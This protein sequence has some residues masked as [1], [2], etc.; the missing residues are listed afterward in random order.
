MKETD[1]LESHPRRLMPAGAQERS[2]M[3]VR[4]W[5]AQPDARSGSRW[6]QWVLLGGDAALAMALA[7]AFY[8]AT[9]V[10]YEDQSRGI[11]LILLQTLPLALRRWY[12][13]SVLAVVVAATLGT[14]AAEIPGRSNGG[15]GVVLLVAL[16]SVAA[17]CPRREAAWAGI[18][19]GAV[20]AWPLWAATGGS[21]PLPLR[22]AVVAMSLVLPTLGW[23]CGAYVGELRGRAARSR[24][25]QE[26]ET[27]RAVAEEQARVGR[28][29]HD[30][31]AHTL[32]VIVIQAGAALDVFD[33]RPQAAR[34]ALGSIGSAGR[35]ALAELRRVL[36]AVRPQPGQEEDWAPPPGLSGLGE[37]LDRVRAAGLDVTARIDGAPVD[38]PAGLDLAAYR[39]VQEA[40]TNT[41]KHARAQAA[42]VHLCY[43]PAGLVL[44]VTDDGRPAAPA[45][46]PGLARGRG[47][48]GIRERA[49]LHGGTCQAGPR[50]GGGFAVRVAFPLPGDRPS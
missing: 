3:G 33:T 41:L 30:V 27:G 40:L 7:A 14:V 39:I 26:L 20:L 8:L 47:L 43:G 42:E 29:L 49:A 31:I 1:L 17:Y 6:R 35:Q 19:A 13:L 11:A 25:E 48:I 22:V 10:H 37:L 24:R 15:V 32:S 38:L 44:E 36:A 9:G 5:H 16:Y 2:L 23:V 34:Q 12:P 46:R 50:P 18:A 28:E 21:A 45:G 4:A